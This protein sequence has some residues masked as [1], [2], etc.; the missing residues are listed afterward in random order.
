M[1]ISRPI[2][3]CIGEIS[4]GVGRYLYAKFHTFITI[5]HLR[6]AFCLCLRMSL[7]AQP[8]VWKY[9]FKT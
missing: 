5:R 4:E 6:V 9:E 7:G 3:K 1:N 2:I 8:F